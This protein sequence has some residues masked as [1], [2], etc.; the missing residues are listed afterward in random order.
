MIAMAELIR[1]F[2][3]TAA[4]RIWRCKAKNRSTLMAVMIN[5]ETPQNEY[6]TVSQRMSKQRSLVSS[7]AIYS[8]CNKTHKKVRKN[9]I[10]QYLHRCCSNARCPYNSS[11]YQ[12]VA[13]D[14]YEKQRSIDNAV[15][16]D[17]VFKAGLAVL[18][19]AMDF[20][21]IAIAHLTDKSWILREKERRESKLQNLPNVFWIEQ[22]HDKLM[23]YLT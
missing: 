6:A 23:S 2:V 18:W 5:K 14:G 12:T 7:L 10:W 15:Y 9:Q 16:N 19:M 17:N 11:Q 1:D 22:N 8:G 20:A 21:N 13:Q 3:I 4:Y